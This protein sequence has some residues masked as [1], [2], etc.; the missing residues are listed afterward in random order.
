M[1]RA[2]VLL[3]PLLAL[4]SKSNSLSTVIH[5]WIQAVQYVLLS[6]ECFFLLSACWS[7]HYLF[8]GWVESLLLLALGS[9]YL[10]QGSMI[11]FVG[12]SISFLD[13]LFFP[14]WLFWTD[15]TNECGW[16]L[17]GGRGSW[18]K[19]PHQIPSVSWLFHHSLKLPHLLDRFI[20]IGNV[21]SSVLLQVLEQWDRWGMFN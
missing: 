12:S 10:G 6:F 8:K 4:G 13:S 15:I 7:C 9:V 18:L 14:G 16:C 21:M 2:L 5:T 20:C 3:V 19:G 1:T 11:R 17:P